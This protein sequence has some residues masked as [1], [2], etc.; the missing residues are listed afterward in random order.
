M[1]VKSIVKAIHV[2]EILSTQ[3]E[4]G[5]TGLAQ[6]LNM[7]K[8][9]VYR[10]LNTLKGLG[11]LVQNPET[12]GYRLSFKM[13]DLARSQLTIQSL[14]DRSHSHLVKL[15]F[16]VNE[17]SKLAVLEG[18]NALT[19]DHVESQHV[20]RICIANGRQFSANLVAIGKAMLAYLDEDTVRSMFAGKKMVAG[21]GKSLTTVHALLQ[22]LRAIR[23][24]GYAI[25]DEECML[26]LYCLAVPVFDVGNQ[27]VAGLSV[28]FPIM[29]NKKKSERD[30][31]VKLLLETSKNITAELSGGP[32]LDL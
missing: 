25:D 26:G 22:D 10:V 21:T 3:G 4:M 27:V 23:E 7:D 11:Y 13:Q 28:S 29:R 17:A 12:Q 19:L 15:T 30:R 8:S 16:E 24:R 32:M 2:L 1:A 9:T 20:I 14:I 31:I 18:S 6:T 5:V